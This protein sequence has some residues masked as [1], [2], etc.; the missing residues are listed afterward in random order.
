M[1]V[2][3]TS[4]RITSIRRKM[5]IKCKAGEKRRIRRSHFLRIR[6]LDLFKLLKPFKDR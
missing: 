3:R 1:L 2:G 6:L 5:I 4:G